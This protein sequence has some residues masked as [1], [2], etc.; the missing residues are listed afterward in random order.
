MWVLFRLVCANSPAINTLGM[1]R[2]VHHLWTEHKLAAYRLHPTAKHVEL[3]ER[4]LLNSSKTGDSVVDL[5]GG[6]GSRSHASAAAREARL[7]PSEFVD[8]EKLV[9][10]ESLV[11]F[12]GVRPP[13]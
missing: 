7:P 11:T 2:G 13:K 12:G 1:G 3:I 9:V 5:F 8:S 10:S 4:A 6:S